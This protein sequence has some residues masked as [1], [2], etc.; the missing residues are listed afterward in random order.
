MTD[1]TSTLAAL[2]AGAVLVLLILWGVSAWRDRR[3][4]QAA[5]RAA[6][7]WAAANPLTPPMTDAA[8]AAFCSWYEEQALHAL[9]LDVGDVAPATREGSRVGGPVWLPE[10]EPWPLGADGRPLSFLAQLDFSELPQIPDFPTSGVLQFFIGRDDLFGANFDTPE[11]GNFK[12]IFRQATA[13]AGAFQLQP[14]CDD[15]CSPMSD[16]LRRSGRRLIGSVC[17]HWP[18]ISNWTLERDHPDLMRSRTSNHIWDHVERRDDA[19]RERHH[20]GGYPDFTQ[21]DFRRNP[22]Y[23]DHDRVLLQLWSYPDRAL[24][25]GDCGQANF[26]IPRADLRALNFNRTTYHW[27]CT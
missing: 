25:W 10:G 22:R 16:D 2:L 19:L 6:A 14:P 11:A 18:P 9:R 12:V 23:A 24:M 21:D 5:R 7:A 17:H 15:D 3:Q 13:G 4:A 26:M 1:T 8:F 20:V 27:D